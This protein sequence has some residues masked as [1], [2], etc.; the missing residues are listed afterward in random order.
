MTTNRMT[1]M[2]AAFESR[3]QLAVEYHPLSVVTRR[4]I[5]KLFI[6]RLG[7]ANSQEELLEQL[8]HLKRLDLNGRQIRNV[9]MIAESLARAKVLGAEGAS[10]DAGSVHVDISHV[11]QALK[12]TLGFREYFKKTKN[13]SHRR[14]QSNIQNGNRSIQEDEDEDE[15]DED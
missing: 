15:D 1:T 12:D 5:W 14:L 4:K 7:N 6:K 8:D 11:N 3:I 10:D 9:M 2:D 13:S